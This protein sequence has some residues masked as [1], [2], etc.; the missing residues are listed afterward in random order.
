MESCNIN[1]SFGIVCTM[2]KFLFILIILFICGILSADICLK[3]IKESEVLIGLTAFEQYSTAIIL[4]KDLFWNLVYERGKLFAIVILLC[5][6]PLKERLGFMMLPLFS[7]IW[8]FFLMSCIMELGVA[9]LVV[10]L[11]SVLPHGILYGAAIWM[12]SSGNKNRIYYRKSN[13]MM[14]AGTYLFIILLFV[15]GCIIESLI[16]TH[17]IPWVIRLSMI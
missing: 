6:T 11:A 14:K 7:F 2:K 1:G 9:G 17:F 15:T 4:F 16:G 12:I 3:Q 5:F 13:P 10:G 8:G